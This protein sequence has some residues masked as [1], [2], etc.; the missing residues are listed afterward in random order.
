MA[1]VGA[2]GKREKVQAVGNP[3]TTGSELAG[4]AQ[5]QRRRLLNRKGWCLDG[6]LF[7]G[8]LSKNN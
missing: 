2:L 4:K 1:R 3:Q 6:R 7:L 8:P 5:D